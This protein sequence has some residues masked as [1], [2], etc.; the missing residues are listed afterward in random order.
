MPEVASETI[1]GWIEITSGAAFSSK[2]F[3]LQDGLPLVRIRDLGK[4]STATRYTGPYDPIFLLQSGD[5]LIGMDGDFSIER[6]EGG[7]ALLNQRVCKVTSRSEELDQG[8][9]FHFFE[10]P[11]CEYSPHHS[12]DNSKAPIDQGPAK[13]RTSPIG[14]CLTE[15]GR[16]VSGRYRRCYPR[17]RCTV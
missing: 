6:W 16:C 15:A 9:L 5:V 1:D 4:G 14:A 13:D 8:F 12:R 7:T 11:N 10:T 3:S 17:G 2:Y